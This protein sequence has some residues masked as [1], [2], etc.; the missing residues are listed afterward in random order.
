MQLL[1]TNICDGV[2]KSFCEEIIEYIKFPSN[3]DARDIRKFA[4][5]F[6]NG[7]NAK[8]EL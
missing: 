3:N 6:L 5:G 4:D 7:A 8:G 2:F 1:F